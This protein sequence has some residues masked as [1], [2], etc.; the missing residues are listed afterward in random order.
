MRQIP[1]DHTAFCVQDVTLVQY[2]QCALPSKGVIF[3]RTV[4]AV[5]FSKLISL[6]LM[7][8]LRGRVGTLLTN[9][10]SATYEATLGSDLACWAKRWAD[11]TIERALPADPSK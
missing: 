10:G 1:R 4:L 6:A 9:A 3:M 2:L 11:A 7:P 8:E 5:L